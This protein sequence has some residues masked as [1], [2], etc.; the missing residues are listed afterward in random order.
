MKRI[1]ATL[2]LAATLFSGPAL[3]ALS[4]AQ[5][6][7]LKAHIDAQ[8]DPSFAAMRTNGD[9]TGMTGWYNTAASPTTSAWREA[10]SK[11]DL[12]ELM[13]L[14]TFDARTAGQRQAWEIMLNNAPINMSRNKMR[15]AVNDIWLVADRDAILT[16]CTEPAS[17]FEVVFGGVSTSTGNITAIKRNVL[18]PATIS[19]ISAAINGSY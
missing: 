2:A 4:S 14:T 10:V 17:R 1:L 8:T 11:S 16:G 9:V 13:N 6:L 3:A 18:G 7:T 15:A 5:L 19:D 12:F